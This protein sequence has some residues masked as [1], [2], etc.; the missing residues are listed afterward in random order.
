MS[1][2]IRNGRGADGRVDLGRIA[3]VIAS[4]DPDVVALQ[5]VDAGRL[6][7]GSVDQSVDLG[8]RLGLDPI[9][10]VCVEKG[11]EQYGIATLTKL[12]VIESHHLALPSVSHRR[13]EPR[14]ALVTR[15]AWPAPSL[16]L[17]VLNTH[18]SVVF[19]ER[20]GQIAAI[21]RELVADE[22]IVAGDLNCTPWSLALRPLRAKV[23]SATGHS[24]TWPAR[25]PLLPL[26][27]ILYGGA[28]SVVDAGP[29]RG[30]PARHA[31]DHLPVVAVLQHVAR[32]EAA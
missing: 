1:Y 28:V 23:T 31:S 25:F 26:D 5:E 9:Y 12:P 22:V 8:V 19:A 4:F 32:A 7:S 21:A 13:S 11:C 15:L 16:T 6:R 10:S 27:H 14:R 18:L 20:P 3:E 2:N 24:R 17:A 30:G 29:W